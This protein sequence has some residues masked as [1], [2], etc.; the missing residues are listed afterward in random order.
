MSMEAS[1]ST[2]PL[3]ALDLSIERKSGEYVLLMRFKYDKESIRFI[4]SLEHV[5]WNSNLRAW[6]MPFSYE[7]YREMKTTLSSRF[8]IK[9]EP[10]REQLDQLVPL[11]E[12]VQQAIK[13]FIL[14]MK[15]KRYSDNTIK[16]YSEAVRVFLRFYRTK[17]ISTIDNDDLVHFNNEYILKNKY[18]SSYQNQVVNALKLFFRIVDQK[19][20]DP[21][22]LH[23]PRRRKRLP[24]VLSKKE[25]KTILDVTVNLKHQCMLSLIYACGLRSGE[26]INL[27]PV[28]IDSSRNLVLIKNAKGKKDRIVPL[29]QKLLTLLRE[30]FRKYK[31]SIYLFEGSEKGKPY[32]Y[33]SLEIVLKKSA[34][35]ANISKSVTLHVLRHSYATH[36][37]ESGTDL[38][39]IQELLGH[40]NSKT[41]EIYTHVST[42]SIQQIKSPFDDL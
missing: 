22:Q 28:D 15:N 30:Y 20:L 16:T 40:K 37:L 21:E 42:K 35:K 31:P 10:G 27:K 14:W 29:S 26:L 1:F 4:R 39:Y 3:P 33:R 41:T 38:R 7:K 24:I 8:E 12:E 32:S 23:R 18:S 11:S 2:N 13:Q 19:H 9:T 6:I 25:V 34:E 36:L 17:S 5:S